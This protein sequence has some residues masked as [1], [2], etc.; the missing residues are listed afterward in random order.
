MVNFDNFSQKSDTTVS[1]SQSFSH[2]CGQD[3]T[4]LIVGGHTG[5]AGISSITYDS[6]TMGR[7]WGQ[8]TDR[9]FLFALTN[10]SKGAN[11]VSITMGASDFFGGGGISFS[12]TEV[13]SGT[14]EVIGITN[15]S[16]PGSVT[17]VSLSI[18]TKSDGSLNTDNLG[19]DAGT[20][21]NTTGVRQSSRYA[22]TANNMSRGSTQDADVTSN[23]T[24]GW[25][26]TTA[27]TTNYCCAE[28]RPPS[29]R[30]QII[31]Y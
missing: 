25:S 15:G 19:T 2:S 5:G 18:A 14:A 12:G 4:C 17:S 20:S 27:T 9:A 26:W 11:T 3:A 30:P 31:S 29:D 13:T 1:S 10:P 7:V 21:F 8:S 6:V 23:Y 28:I 16:S 22:A 24:V